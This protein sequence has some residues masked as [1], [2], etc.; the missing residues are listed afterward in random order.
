MK[1]L[2]A[3]LKRVKRLLL[4]R[5]SDRMYAQL[6]QRTAEA[7]KKISETVEQAPQ[8]CVS[9]RLLHMR[10]EAEQKQAELGVRLGRL[11][12]HVQELTGR[13]D[14]LWKD[15]ERRRAEDPS[16]P[17]V[18]DPELERRLIDVGPPITH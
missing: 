6:E 11:V 4:E 17:Y 15:Y 9:T 12:D 1:T 14:T 3:F 2:M 16:S 10:A 7:L 5:P 13:T 18:L 8:I